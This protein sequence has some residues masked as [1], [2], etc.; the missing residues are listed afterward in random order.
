MDVYLSTILVSNPHIRSANGSADG[1][2]GADG[3][4]DSIYEVT[5]S[6]LNGESCHIPGHAKMCVTE[7]IQNIARQL[8]GDP[9][10][11]LVFFGATELKVRH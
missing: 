9:S 3:A 2:D 1:A 11:Q 7:L 4:D 8:G 6:T 5:V 10:K